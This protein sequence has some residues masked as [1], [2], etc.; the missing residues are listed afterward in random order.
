MRLWNQWTLKKSLFKH[1]WY[2][3]VKVNDTFVW[4]FYEINK[5]ITCSFKYT[6]V[7]LIFD[8]F[9]LH[10]KCSLN[11]NKKTRRSSLQYLLFSS[12]CLNVNFRTLMSYKSRR[13]FIGFFYYRFHIIVIIIFSH[14][15]ANLRSYVLVEWLICVRKFV[16]QKFFLHTLDFFQ[17][18]GNLYDLVFQGLSKGIFNLSF[19]HF[20]TSI[21]LMIIVFVTIYHF[22]IITCSF[23]FSSYKLPC[24][25]DDDN[26][27][28][29]KWFILY[30]RRGAL[31]SLKH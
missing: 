9:F 18:L 30:V 14:L 19:L 10:L 6:N 12:W 1:Q 5:Q 29:L 7:L 21:V 4:M 11:V 20:A 26:Q 23:S 15:Y 25:F 31:K 17:F 2:L 28:V 8:N 3:L 16:T 24:M 22:M 13:S 27:K